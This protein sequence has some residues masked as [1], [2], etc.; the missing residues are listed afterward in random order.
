MFVFKETTQRIIDSRM[1]SMNH[2]EF[3]KHLEKHNH[4][5]IAQFLMETDAIV[6][7]EDLQKRE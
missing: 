6:I 3:K 1:S 7:T 2:E 4:G 5:N